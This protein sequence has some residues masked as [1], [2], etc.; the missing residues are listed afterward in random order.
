MRIAL[1]CC[2][3]GFGHA[4][5]LVTLYE[6]LQH[7]YDITI[8]CPSTVSGYIREKVPGARINYIPRFTFVKENGRIRYY[9]TVKT[10]LTTLG[11]MPWVIDRLYRRLV[12][13][14]I[15]AVVTDF[16]PFTS[17]AAKRGGIPVIE[18]NH[19]GMILNHFSLIPSALASKIVARFMESWYDR[20]INC[21]FY[22]SSHGPLIRDEIA[23]QKPERGDF[24]L[25][26]LNGMSREAV[27]D[28]LSPFSKE[29]F[30][31]FPDGERDFV[32]SLAACKGVITTAGHQLIS[33]AVSLGKPLFVIPMNGQ[34]EQKLNGKML[35]RSGWGMTGG[36]DNLDELLPGFF[37]KI[38]TY[39]RPVMDQLT[40]F[41]L[42]NDKDNIIR[43][44]EMFFAESKIKRRRQPSG[45]I[46]YTVRSILRYNQF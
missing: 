32:R 31:V 1:S 17:L 29:S 12:D 39:P 46:L 28:L 44:I 5:R 21:S 24:Y 16:D 8:L 36:L 23:R 3:E 9:W 10:N 25:V 26:Y 22:G 42:T 27:F 7:R 14:R 41:I 34:Y 4:S 11:R 6:E 19:P 40:D 13:L 38:N 20:K 15:E 18:F 35:E 33:E 45:K 37:R 43:S 30:R 2:G